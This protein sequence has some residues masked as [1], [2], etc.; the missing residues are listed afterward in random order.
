MDMESAPP[1]RPLEII[2]ASFVAHALLLLAAAHAVPPLDDL[3]T[4]AGAADQQYLLHVFTTASQDPEEDAPPV[5]GVTRI[6]P[7][8]EER[9]LSRCGEHRGG[10]MGDPAAEHTGF[11]YGVQGP[12][13]NP[14]P[15]LA[16]RVSSA[17]AWDWQIGLSRPGGWGGDPGAPTVIW[18]R[19][20][21]LGTDAAS[22]RGNV[23][24]EGLGAAAGSPGAGVGWRRLCETCGATGRGRDDGRTAP[25][26]AVGTESAAMLA[27]LPR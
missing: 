20:D 10:S 21:S 26:G 17:D 25:G 18:G 12:A 11:R 1:D 15:H 14:D 27:R 4:P 19:D 23:W 3:E 7:D 8:D 9:A 13:D 24:G 2:V 22:A 5:E 6:D 16:Q